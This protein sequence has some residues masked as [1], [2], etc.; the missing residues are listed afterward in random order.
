MTGLK[1]KKCHGAKGHKDKVMIL[2]SQNADGNRKR[3]SC[4]SSKAEDRI[5]EATDELQFEQR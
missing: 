2:L 1:I 4:N 5:V 3:A